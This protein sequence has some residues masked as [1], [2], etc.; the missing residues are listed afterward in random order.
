MSLIKDKQFYYLNTDVQPG[1]VL[2]TEDGST[3]AIWES[4]GGP[5][6]QWQA[7]KMAE[8]GEWAFQSAEY[9]NWIMAPG[10][11][12]DQQLQLSSLDPSLNQ[13]LRW[14]VT[15]PADAKTI[16]SVAYPG[17][18]QEV[19]DLQGKDPSNGTPIILYPS[20]DGLNQMWGFAPV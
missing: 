1:Q 8:P 6:Q 10:I 17:P 14:K 9:L 15:G 7:H 19:A 12:D 16:K 3:L 13:I 20:N 4:T 5:N 11:G 18:P 2:S